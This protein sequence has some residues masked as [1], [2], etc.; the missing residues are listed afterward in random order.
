M[1]E[2]IFLNKFFT[3]RSFACARRAEEYKVNHDMVFSTYVDFKNSEYSIF[4]LF[5]AFWPERFINVF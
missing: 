3:L 5:G 2:A 1:S 4:M